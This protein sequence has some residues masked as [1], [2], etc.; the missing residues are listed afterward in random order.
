MDTAKQEGKV[1]F[2]DALDVL[3]NTFAARI[4]GDLRILDMAHPEEIM[5]LIWGV[6][7]KF[8]GRAPITGQERLEHLQKFARR[9]FDA[10]D[11]NKD[12]FVEKDEL[13]Q[14]IR[15]TMM[16]DIPPSMQVSMKDELDQEC[17]DAVDQAY[18]CADTDRDDRL[19]FDEAYLAFWAAGIFI[20]LEGEPEGK[21]AAESAA[22]VVLDSMGPRA[23]VEIGDRFRKMSKSLLE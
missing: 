3:L 1:T 16:A 15:G 14:A 8:E 6:A 19:T 20:E 2:D 13:K 5:K 21:E 17:N 7:L 4:G 23:W 12:G 18:A 10:I 9:V 22:L 11:A